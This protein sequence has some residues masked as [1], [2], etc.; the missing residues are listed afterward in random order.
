MEVKSLDFGG[1]IIPQTVTLGVYCTTVDLRDALIAKHIHID[2]F[3]TYALSLA[4]FPVAMRTITLGTLRLK[5][6][7]L[8][9]AQGAFY[10]EVYQRARAGMNFFPAEFAILLRLLY[11]DQPVGERLWVISDPVKSVGD[12]GRFSLDHDPHDGLCVRGHVGP[13]QIPLGPEED[14]VL[15]VVQRYESR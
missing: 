10:K 9:F 4:G 8:G 7:N 11:L 14:I 2:R 1:G 6:T 12:K 13:D 5:V 15:P 3:T